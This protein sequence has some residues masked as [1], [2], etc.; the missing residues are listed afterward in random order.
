MLTFASNFNIVSM[1]M[2][3]LMQRM[4]VKPFL[5]ICVLLPLLLLFSKT[6]TQT[7]TLCVNGPEVFFCNTSARLLFLPEIS[8]K[9][10]EYCKN[11][12]H[13]FC[14]GNIGGSIVFSKNFSQ[15]DKGISHVAF[16]YQCHSLN[17]GA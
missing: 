11:L 9:R 10:L 16:H 15:F 14:L 13:R 12:L 4:G 5:C 2:L 6:Q 7:L 17:L 3:T 8:I 1:V